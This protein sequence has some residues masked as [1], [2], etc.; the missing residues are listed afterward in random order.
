MSLLVSGPLQI[1]SVNLLKG[2][3]EPKHHTS[4]YELSELVIRRGTP[5]SLMLNL[6]RA[7]VSDESLQFEL[8]IGEL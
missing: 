6:S 1:V 2:D 7:L 5:F 3:N 4:D 8:R